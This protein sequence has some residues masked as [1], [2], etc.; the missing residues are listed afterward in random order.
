M[1]KSTIVFYA[2]LIIAATASTINAQ[3]FDFGIKAGLNVAS[4][5]GEDAGDFDSRTGIAIGG[6]LAYPLSNMF[7]IQPELLYTMKGA[8]QTQ[9]FGGVEYTGTLKL[10]YLEIPVLGKLIIP[11]KN[12]TMKPM[13]YVGPSLAFKI[14]SKLHLKGGDLDDQD[15]YE[16][17]KS[18]D[19]GFV[20]GGGVGF[21]VG[22]NTLGVEIRYDFGLTSIDDSGDDANIKN[23]V[24]ML[25]VSFEI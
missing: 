17:I 10:N 23:N 24:L 14:S 12:P 2:V 21:P 8:T 6:F 7:Y 20:V 3:P 13:V 5:G 9:T 11:M 22:S 19:L 4:I 16:G 25:M 18:T 15:D 1:R